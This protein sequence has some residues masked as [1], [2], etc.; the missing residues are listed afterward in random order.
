VNAAS[1]AARF[2]N[3]LHAVHACG[4]YD[5]LQQG[6]F[7]NYLNIKFKDSRMENV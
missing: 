4:D 6:V 2:R 1:P 7:E 3:I 5:R